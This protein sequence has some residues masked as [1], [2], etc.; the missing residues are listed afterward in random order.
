VFANQT[1]QGRG[2]IGSRIGAIRQANLERFTIKR[3]TRML[4]RLNLDVE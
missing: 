3:L 4:D 1:R 2:V